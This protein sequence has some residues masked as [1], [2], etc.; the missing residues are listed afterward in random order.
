MERKRYNWKKTFDFEEFDGEYKSKFINIKGKRLKF[1]HQRLYDCKNLKENGCQAKYKEEKFDDDSIKAYVT[2]EHN[3]ICQATSKILNKKKIVLK[4]ISNNN[5][6]NWEIKEAFNLNGS[7]ITSNKINNTKE[8]KTKNDIKILLTSKHTLGFLE[9]SH[10]LHIDATYN[11]TDLEYPIIVL[12]VSDN[13]GMFLL[14]GLDIVSNKKSST[15]KWVSDAL[16]E[17]TTKN[18]INFN[19]KYLIEDSSAAITNLHVILMK[20]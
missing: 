15:Y 8:I 5:S 17:E 11:I 6:R 19:I 12:G 3:P 1:C 7:T 20:K 10:M 14:V 13:N 18:N 9:K 4:E 2:N 16:L